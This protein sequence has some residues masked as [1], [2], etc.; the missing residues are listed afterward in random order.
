MFIRPGF[1]SSILIVE[2]LCSWLAADKEKKHDVG[3]VVQYVGNMKT[4]IR[5]YRE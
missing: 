5:S 2:G 3:S 1:H 4:I